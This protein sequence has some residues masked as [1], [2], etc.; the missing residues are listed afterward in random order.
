VYIT[1]LLS[2]RVSGSPGLAALNDEVLPTF[3]RANVKFQ[4]SPQVDR[5]RGLTTSNMKV[6]PTFRLTNMKLRIYFEVRE[7][8]Y[9]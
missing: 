8:R 9:Q 6:I 4:I 3:R 2:L 5:S 7:L 1:D